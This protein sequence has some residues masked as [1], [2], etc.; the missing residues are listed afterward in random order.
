MSKKEPRGIRASLR[1]I[2]DKAFNWAELSKKLFRSSSCCF[3][4]RLW[5]MLMK[6]VSLGSLHPPNPW[7][8]V[9]SVMMLVIQY[10]LPPFGQSTSFH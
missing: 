1:N 9:I 6:H 10:I 8:I 7:N 2:V 4:F 3:L 5:L